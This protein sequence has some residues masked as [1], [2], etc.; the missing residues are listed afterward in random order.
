MTS[1]KKGFTLIE[2]LVV[3]SIIALLL[4]ILMP[5]LGKVKEK[6]REVMCRSNLKQWSY[7]FHLYANDNY[8][9]LMPALTSASPGGGTWI[10]SLRPY[11]G[12]LGKKMCICPN[13]TKSENDGETRLGRRA[14]EYFD[15]EDN[16]IRKNSYAI[17][18][19]CYNIQTNV[20]EI[21]A[22]KTW[23]K[24]D[25]PLAARIPLFLEGWR[26]GGTPKRRSNPAQDPEDNT[27]G[28]YQYSQ[29]R[30]NV[31]RHQGGIG[32]CFM[33]GHVDRVNLKG[34]WDLKWHKQYDLSETLPTWPD[35]MKGFKD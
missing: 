4:A 6:G 24:L 23:G 3:I 29:Q 13:A 21:E 5:A 19:W 16:E 9:K 22:D 15:T 25:S 28:T 35:W 30:F 10:F 17:N 20:W 33:D 26:W 27:R 8:G 14:W 32:V 31:N 18:N 11:Y 1:G 34:L 7:V 12:D 2:L